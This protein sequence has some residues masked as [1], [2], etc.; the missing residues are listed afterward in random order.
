MKKLAILVMLFMGLLISPLCASHESN[1]AALQAVAQRNIQ[2]Y[3][4]TAITSTNVKTLAQTLENLV[5]R[6]SSDLIKI[7]DKHLV[8]FINGID[9]ALLQRVL[10]DFM[11]SVSDPLNNKKFYFKYQDI[12]DTLDAILDKIQNT[13]KKLTVIE[14][15]EYPAPYPKKCAFYKKYFLRELSL[16]SVPSKY[17]E[18]RAAV[19]KKLQEEKKEKNVQARKDALKYFEQALGRK[20]TEVEQ[21]W[22]LDSFKIE[23]PLSIDSNSEYSCCML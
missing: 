15:L 6:R 17:S 20:P 7:M 11:A 12:Y 19:E 10:N 13:E 5:Q 23:R 22:V 8:D 4:Q 14:L 3:V 1:E 16:L 21:N 2:A 9:N 18:K